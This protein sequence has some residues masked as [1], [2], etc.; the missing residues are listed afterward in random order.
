MFPP[1]FKG[2]LGK[3]IKDTAYMENSFELTT[4]KSLGKYQDSYLDTGEM[5]IELKAK[6]NDFDLPELAFIGLDTK[7]I[8]KRIGANYF[9]KDSCIVYTYRNTA[10]I[11]KMDNRNKI[12]WLKYEKLNANLSKDKIPEGLLKYPE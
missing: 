11:I 4:Y 3:N 2:Y 6:Y 8:K 10:L 12:E 1:A 5:L 7:E 9:M